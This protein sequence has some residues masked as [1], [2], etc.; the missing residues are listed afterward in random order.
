MLLRSQSEKCLQNAGLHFVSGD[1]C[2]LSVLIFGLVEKLSLLV[3]E[4]ITSCVTVQK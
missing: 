1:I 3:Q 2:Q 4:L